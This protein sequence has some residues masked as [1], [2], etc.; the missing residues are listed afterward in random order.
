M[1]QS[2]LISN[3]INTLLTRTSVTTIQKVNSLSLPST[4]TR[5]F[6]LFAVIK[7]IMHTRTH[8]HTHTHTKSTDA[9]Q[10]AFMYQC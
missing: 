10:V 2:K 8:V 5:Y 3:S 6:D 7:R 4:E 9:Q 1:T